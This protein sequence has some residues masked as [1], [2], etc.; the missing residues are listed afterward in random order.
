VADNGDVIVAIGDAGAVAVV[1]GGP[2]GFEPVAAVSLSRL[3]QSWP[4]YHRSSERGGS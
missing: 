3:G 1:G 4:K 2:P